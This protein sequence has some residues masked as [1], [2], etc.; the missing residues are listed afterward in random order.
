ML[1]HSF[2]LG[3]WPICQG[4]LQGVHQGHGK[5][6]RHPSS[7]FSISKHCNV[8]PVKTLCCRRKYFNHKA[9]KGY[10]WEFSKCPKSE[11]WKPDLSE[12]QRNETLDFRQELENFLNMYTVNVCR[13]SEIR[14]M[15]KLG[16]S[17]YLDF[18]RRGFLIVSEIGIKPTIPIVQNPN[19]LS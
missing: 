5:C 9:Q 2:V 16:H 7:E 17:Y 1:C 14:T 4:V 13:T 19:T 12:K 6:G 8:L 10:K 3:H 11:I 15:R 18:R